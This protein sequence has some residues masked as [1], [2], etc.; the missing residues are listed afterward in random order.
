M[1]DVISPL[2]P[3]SRIILTPSF[4]PDGSNADLRGDENSSRC[5]PYRYRKC[6][7]H[8]TSLTRNGRA[9]EVAVSIGRQTGRWRSMPSVLP[10]QRSAYSAS[11]KTGSGEL[12]ISS[13]RG[14]L[15]PRPRFVQGPGCF[16]EHIIR[17][18][19]QIALKK[20]PG[21]CSSEGED[22]RNPRTQ[23]PNL[24]IS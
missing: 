22:P 7:A 14:R 4:V 8:A 21:R 20:E 1:S 13:M 19:R 24:R 15:A 12:P 6:G 16:E 23:A 10:L 3:P 18:E 2:F 9:W 17:L 5:G 11:S